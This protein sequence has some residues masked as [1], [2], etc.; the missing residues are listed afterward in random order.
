MDSMPEMGSRIDSIRD[1]IEQT[2]EKINLN[3]LQKRSTFT[4][5]EIK[6]DLD[7][8]KQRISLVE[9]TLVEQRQKTGQAS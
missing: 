9:K 4:S 3:K 8:I 1:Q 6:S 7:T 2:K 5:S